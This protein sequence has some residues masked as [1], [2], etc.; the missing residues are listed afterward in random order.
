MTLELLVYHS[1]QLV[2]STTLDGPL[3]IGRQQQGEPDPY[4][5]LAST[6]AARLIIAG[7]TEASLS[8]RHVHL[9]PSDRG[10]VRVRN[11]SG[12]VAVRTG[13][14][15]TIEPGSDGELT[16]P[17]VLWLGDRSL[18]VA[19]AIADSEQQYDV[20]ALNAATQP[21]GRGAARASTLTSLPADAE[22]AKQ[23]VQWLESALEVFQSAASSPAFFARAAG[24][25]VELVGLDVAAVMRW[26]GT[27]WKTEQ[28]VTRGGAELAQGWRPSVTMLERTRREKRTFRRAPKQR[29]A[30]LLG[31][32]ALVVAPILDPANEV[33]GALYGDRRQVAP[34]ADRPE[35]TELEALL[36]ELLAS[37]VAA[38]L[39][40]LAQERA[41][42]AARVRFEQFF[43]PELAEQLELQPDLL[44]G[45]DA[46]ISVLFCD[47]RG[48]SRISERLGP[49]RTV[50]WISDVMEEL[51]E[52]VLR[53]EGV[54]V[55]YV[56][57]ELIA[58]WGAPVECTDH[59]ER[60]CRAALAM[61]DK[62]AALNA[63]WADELG[64]TTN[65]GVGVNSGRARVGNTGSTRKFKYGPLGNTV[66]LA[67]RVQG[68]TKHLRSPLLVTG[69]T[70][71]QLSPELNRR[72]LSLVRVVNI[73]E[74]VDLYEVVAPADGDWIAFRD[75]YEDALA[76]LEG[77]EFFR[78]TQLLGNLVAEFPDDGPSLLLL[79][80]A[81]DG[82]IHRDDFDPVW[83][84]ASK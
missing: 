21:P 39:A 6:E 83:E 57:D 33:V 22:L 40:R 38:G 42:L 25:V 50:A 69:Q 12:A 5:R 67:S 62:L 11:L 51:S 20:V 10:V 13:R 36:V 58:M 3:E 56:G 41:A 84:L 29:A 52:C 74:P 54:L 28:T 19:P 26:D 55:D 66:N 71:S 63:R 82:L 16:A 80:R 73:D 23:L 27:Q 17:F 72:R 48:F 65:I 4:C 79:S 76:A 60:A 64:Q 1:Q 81:V 47:V 44:S 34:Q 31:V 9:E 8:R 14:G 75:R 78:A 7:M 59:A 43:T 68:A 70:A 46:E 30:S 32:E 18:H 45:K 37:G 35:I 24:A 49:L 61:N 77:R 2:F 53:H 15:E